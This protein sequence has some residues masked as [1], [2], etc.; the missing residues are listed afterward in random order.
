MQGLEPNPLNHKHG[1]ATSSSPNTGL[2]QLPNNRNSDLP[3]NPKP[4]KTHP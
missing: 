4:L 2:P 3:L 1:L